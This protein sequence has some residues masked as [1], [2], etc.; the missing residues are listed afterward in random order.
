M[1]ESFKGKYYRKIKTDAV[2]QT[3]K[4]MKQQALKRLCPWLCI[5]EVVDV[6]RE[7]LTSSIG[8]RVSFVAVYHVL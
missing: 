2:S 5:E 8:L 6:E 7:K 1:L 3:L 4:S